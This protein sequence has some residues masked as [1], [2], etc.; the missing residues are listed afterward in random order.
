MKSGD[1]VVINGGSAGTVKALYFGVENSTTVCKRALVYLDT[2]EIGT[3][4]PDEF[5]LITRVT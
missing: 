4:A 1:R 2:G 3:Y 5:R